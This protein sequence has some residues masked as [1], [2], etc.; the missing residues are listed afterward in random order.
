MNDL[1][2][3]AMYDAW[4]AIMPVAEPAADASH[5]AYDFVGPV[6]ETG[7]IFA[8][9]RESVVLQAGDLVALRS[10]GAYGATMAST[11]NSRALAPE[12]LVRGD[13]HAV[14]RRR[15]APREMMALDDFAPWLDG[16]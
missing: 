10:A 1:L 13:S 5:V 9:D 16:G 8:R 2:R 11:Y 3:P 7:D 4:H 14:I 12:V 6:C 15:V